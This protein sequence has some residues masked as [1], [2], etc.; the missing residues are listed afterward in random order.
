MCEGGL[1]VAVGVLKSCMLRLTSLIE[2][3][4][5]PTMTSDHSR[6]EVY[7]T[8]VDIKTQLEQLST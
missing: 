5:M 1:I 3:E 2:D 8:C 4:V 7:F 6:T